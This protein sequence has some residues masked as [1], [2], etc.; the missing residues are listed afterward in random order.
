ML[1]VKYI[2]VIEHEAGEGLLEFDRQVGRP[3]RSSQVESIVHC[4]RPYLR[5]SYTVRAVRLTREVQQSLL[6]FGN[7]Y[8]Q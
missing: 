6:Q 3:L 4:I 5:E 7:P 1:P 2:V 8:G